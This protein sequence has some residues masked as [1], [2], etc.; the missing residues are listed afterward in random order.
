MRLL[1]TVTFNPNQL[2][3][4]LMPLLAVPEVERIVLVADT[5]DEELAREPKLEFRVPTARQLRVLGRAGSKTLLC[6][7]A[8]REI[9]PDWVISWNIMP[10]GVNGHLAARSV[11]ARSMYHMIGGWEEWEGGGWA[12]D[13]ALLSRLP[14][15]VAAIE[16]ALLKV[17]RSSTLVG[18][19]GTRG[20]ARLAAE[21]VPADRVVVTPASIDMDRFSPAEMDAEVPYDLLTV[22]SLI[23]RKQQEDFILAVA[24]L[25][26][27]RPNLRAAIAGEGP[28]RETLVAQAE[29]LGVADAIDFL[30]QRSDVASVYRS[31]RV[32]V[33]PS[34][35][36]GLSIAMMEAMACGLPAVV[37]SVGDLDD[38]VRTG[39]NG[40]VVPLGD[41]PALVAAIAP[42]LDDADY[43]RA[44][45]QTAR[46]D[47][48]RYAGLENMTAR[49]RRMLLALPG[50][51]NPPDVQRA[52]G[53]V[54]EAPTTVGAI[55]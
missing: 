47:V 50:E 49:Y 18:T 17:I 44:L 37:T 19:M 1:A 22:G 15:P 41:V 32:F 24:A 7:R 13:T 38:L 3:A 11:R 16:A 8:A 54:G 51:W 55:K 6:R 2:R 36:E 52:S 34:R 42:L 21:G 26:E 20:K 30:G 45:S 14:R 33:L 48:T 23:A 4:H 35:F 25:R 27:A 28:L 53:Q 46:E 29:R 5:V 31:A 12:S 40:A 10:H 39:R 9:R 43:Y